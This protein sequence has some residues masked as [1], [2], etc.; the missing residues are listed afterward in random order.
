M[1]GYVAEPDGAFTESRSASR[2]WNSGWRR[3]MR[4]GCSTAS[5]E[6]Q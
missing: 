2:S 6:E 1:Q 3:R 5:S 4:Q